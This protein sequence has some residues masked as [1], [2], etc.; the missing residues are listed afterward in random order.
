CFDFSSL[1]GNQNDNGRTGREGEGEGAAGEGEGAAG[2]GEGAAGEG[3]GAAGEG[4][5]E[6]VTGPTWV[7]VAA[8]ITAQAELASAQPS[9]LSSSGGRMF[10]IGSTHVFEMKNDALTVVATPAVPCASEPLVG[11]VAVDGTDLLIGSSRGAV[12]FH[13]D[14][15]CDA[16][17]VS[18][19][20]QA[21]ALTAFAGGVLLFDGQA[22]HVID[23]SGADV[24][25]HAFDTFTS[26]AFYADPSDAHAA[27]LVRGDAQT[28]GQSV[29]ITKPGSELV[30]EIVTDVVGIM[31]GSASATTTIDSSQGAPFL[32]VSVG[33]TTK[34]LRL[35]NTD[36][37]TAIASD[38][39]G[40]VAIVGPS[41][42]AARSDISSATFTVDSLSGVRFGT[43]TRIEQSPGGEVWAFGARAILH[44]SA[45]G[46]AAFADPDVIDVDVN[47]NDRGP[48]FAID[49]SL[50]FTDVNDDLNRA[51][52]SAHSLNIVQVVDAVQ[53]NPISVDSGVGRFAFLPASGT[54]P[55]RLVEANPFEIV[56]YEMTPDLGAVTATLRGAGV[57]LSS[58]VGIAILPDA[59]KAA[60]A[61]F[62]ELFACTIVVGVGVP[63]T[64][65]CDGGRSL[66]IG[67]ATAITIVDPSPGVDDETYVVAANS[68]LAILDP[69]SSSARVFEIDGT[70][71]QVPPLLVHDCL[72]AFGTESWGAL[73]Q[74]QPLAPKLKR[75]FPVSAAAV[76]GDRVLVV[77][78][79]GQA[80]QLA[81]FPAPTTNTCAD[82][83][84]HPILDGAAMLN[85]ELRSQTNLTAVS[86]LSGEL[87]VLDADGLVWHVPTP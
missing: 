53:L 48:A 10:A 42:L 39:D 14:G 84:G 49:G 59:S 70:N 21:L 58:A 11:P 18:G 8:P 15:S 22:V 71:A 81:S 13:Q 34:G 62:D 9:Q 35:F 65:T 12:R 32:D 37:I 60:Y 52:A 1:G 5:G 19:D 55:A 33:T 80:G 30:V 76:V 74:A 67:N 28:P 78:G 4:E 68:E 47:I 26:G 3:E 16:P 45:G 69:G 23:S 6:G 7:K 77:G 20:A 31:A 73:D 82:G 41:A 27:I 83:A 38:D 75:A 85:G 24:A 25:D 66:G 51:D 46:A 44:W 17:Y 43:P 50:F 29:R 87:Y 54:D 63:P 2:E 36:S 64:V 56:S 61:E 79:G 40:E 72:I 86:F 57:N